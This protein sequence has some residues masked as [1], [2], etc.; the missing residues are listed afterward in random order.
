[1]KEIS[2]RQWGAALRRLRR[3]YGGGKITQAQAIQ[4]A[5]LDLGAVSW[6]VRGRSGVVFGP[7]TTK[8]AWFVGI[9]CGW[10]G[11]S[12]WS[13][14][15]PIYRILYTLRSAIHIHIDRAR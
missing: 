3:S 5:G 9:V 7:L 10:S 2:V 14:V 8:V 11:W 6:L 4:R 15:P 13:G 1:M 12:G